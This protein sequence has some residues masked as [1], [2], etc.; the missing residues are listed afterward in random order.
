VE[1]K[2]AIELEFTEAELN[3]IAASM[4]G[5][6][7]ADEELETWVNEVLD[8]KLRSLGAYGDVPDAEPA[9]YSAENLPKENDLVRVWDGIGQETR[10]GFVECT[11][12]KN[13]NVRFVH[14]GT[15]EAHTEHFMATD[16]TLIYRPLSGDTT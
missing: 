8:E 14:E 2:L 5:L 6:T 3:A 12:R 13:A 10:I 7:P 11:F 9:P 16:L 1:K 15:N 4:T